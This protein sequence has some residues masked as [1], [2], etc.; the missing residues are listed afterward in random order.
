MPLSQSAR[1]QDDLGFCR[2]RLADRAVP[3]RIVIVGSVSTPEA[4]AE[5]MGDLTGENS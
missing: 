3:H 4:G 2:R 5:K 1:E